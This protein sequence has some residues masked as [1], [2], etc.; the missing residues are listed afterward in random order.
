MLRDG[1]YANQELLAALL[2]LRALERSRRR[3]LLPSIPNTVETAA[4]GC[5][6]SANR[7]VAEVRPNENGPLKSGPFS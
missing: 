6:S 2:L 4:I 3:A 7:S 5:D 1:S